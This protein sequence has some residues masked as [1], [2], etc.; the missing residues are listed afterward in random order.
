MRTA[1]PFVPE[2]S[3]SGT[4]V[5]IRKLKRYKL[6]GVYQIPT[7]LIQAGGITLHSEVHKHINLIQNKE[8]P[9]QW[10]ASIV[11][12]IH[13]QDDNTDCRNYRG[14]SLL[15]TSNK[16]LSNILLIKL[17]PNAD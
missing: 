17:T 7:E 5:A 14:M 2:P 1:K 15:S 12:P 16:I 3:A 4:G 11:I 13:K 8:F 10:K 6:P 9:H